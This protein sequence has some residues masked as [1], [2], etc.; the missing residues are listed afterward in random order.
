MAITLRKFRRRPRRTRRVQP[1]QPDLDRSPFTLG[2][3]DAPVACLLIHGFSGSP[4]EMR[5]LGGYL[6]GRGVRVEGVRLAGHGTEPED[7]TYLTWRDWL[8]SAAEGLA[9]L[10]QEGRKIVVIGFSMGGLL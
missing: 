9:R 5:W 4:P 10:A 7:L 8:Q 6:A 3:V 1:P 2:P